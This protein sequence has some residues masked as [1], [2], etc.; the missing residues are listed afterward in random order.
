M[1]WIQDGN[2]ILISN[3][4]VFQRHPSPGETVLKVEEKLLDQ[5][6][7]WGPTFHTEHR[8]E[9]L[10]NFSK[11]ERATGFNRNPVYVSWAPSRDLWF[12]T[13][14]LSLDT[15]SVPLQNLKDENHLLF[16]VSMLCFRLLQQPLGLK[17]LNPFTFHLFLGF[18]KQLYCTPEGFL[19]IREGRGPQRHAG[20]TSHEDEQAQESR[21]V[22]IWSS[23]T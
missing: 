18:L 10:V 2:S 9:P 20:C 16:C 11:F 5:E 4:L 7:N 13:L 21:N 17:H 14:I 23:S 3:S 8:L 1:C 6:S 19:S 15:F 22:G 12:F